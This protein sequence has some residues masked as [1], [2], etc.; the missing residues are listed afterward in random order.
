MILLFSKKDR[1]R[2]IAII[3]VGFAVL[4]FGMDTMS[5]AVKPL[6]DVPEF[7]N[8]LLVFQN[9]FLGILAGAVLT[10]VL[11]SSSAS[12][13]ILQALCATGAVSYG[14]A[15]PII[16][17]QNIG[18]CVTAL[19]SSVGTSKNARRAAIV[20]LYF[21]LIGTAAFMAVFYGINAA[22]GFP[23]IGVS[24]EPYGI[25]IAHSVFNIFATCLLL[26]FSDL[27]ERLAYLTIKEDEA[28][29]AAVRYVEE[30]IRALDSRFMHNPAVAMEQCRNCLLYTSDAA[31]D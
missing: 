3:F 30:D 19:L 6:A 17:G 1:R 5:G 26:P 13:G 12:V 16:L 4:M 9:P 21:N 15:I 31:D 23:F 27:L 22:I 8:L 11:Q 18:T 24:A 7:A 29:H 10:A 14:T 25:A 20:H 28:E 2:N